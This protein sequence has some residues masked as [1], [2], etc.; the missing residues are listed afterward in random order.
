MTLESV[1]QTL[2]PCDEAALIAYMTAGFPTLD[3][4]IDNM[5]RL[6]ENGA[7]ILEIG[8]PFSDPIADGPTIQFASK[9]ALDHGFRLSDLLD[10]LRAA[11]FD[12]PVV[13][14][15]YLNPLLAWD[16]DRLFHRM[17]DV[18]IVGLIVPDLPI[19]EA[20]GWIDAARA[21]D[22]HIIH[23]VAP[24]STPDRIRRIADKSTAFVYYV[25]V[26]GTTGGRDRLPDGLTAAL[27]AL[28]AS[29]PVP[30]A[31]GFGISRPEQIRQLH[32]HAD[33]VVVGSRFIEAVRDHEPLDE[34][35]SSLK[36][37]TRSVNHARGHEKGRV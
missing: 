30:V 23:L 28:R 15:S 19:T 2:R 24:T 21:S 6:A 22:I 27:D 25:S 4:S 12:R 31:V 16:R 8:I 1:F 37:A 3:A 34:L 18:G 35:V 32:G 11:R 9:N 5:R 13:A 36:Q 26:T 29:S 7:D 10:A 14:M 17:R 20:D 33:A